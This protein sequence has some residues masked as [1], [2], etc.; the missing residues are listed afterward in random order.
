ME[1]AAAERQDCPA[2]P[3]MGSS[4]RMIIT[5]RTAAF[6]ILLWLVR[7]CWSAKARPTFAG[8]RHRTNRQSDATPSPPGSTTDGR[9]DQRQHGGGMLCS[10]WP[11][12]SRILTDCSRNV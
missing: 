2:R 12:P 1:V 9:C 8:V 10:I 4:A 11:L 7:D 6:A 5:E 3:G